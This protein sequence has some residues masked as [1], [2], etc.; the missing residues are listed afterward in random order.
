MYNEL[1][2][3]SLFVLEI[4]LNVHP[5]PYLYKMIQFTYSASVR[6]IRGT[7]LLTLAHVFTG[8]YGFI[9]FIVVLVYD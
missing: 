1:V 5:P 2:T 7:F 8:N 4:F 3:L 9:H 6:I